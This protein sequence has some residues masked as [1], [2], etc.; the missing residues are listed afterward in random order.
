MSKFWVL[1]YTWRKVKTTLSL[2]HKLEKAKKQ[3]DIIFHQRGC[4][5]SNIPSGPPNSRTQ[6]K[7]KSFPLLDGK[8]LIIN[9]VLFRSFYLV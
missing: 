6:I 4:N 7:N 5:Q 9:T 8:I 2:E 1:K 3:K